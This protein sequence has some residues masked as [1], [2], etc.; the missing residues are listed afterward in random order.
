MHLIRKTAAI[1][2]LAAL[3]AA[4]GARLSEEEIAAT[5]GDGIAAGESGGDGLAAGDGTATDDGTGTGGGVL[6]AGDSTGIDT[7]TGSGDAGGGGGGDSGGA[8]GGGGGGGETAVTQPSGGNGGATDV[9]V[10]ENEILLGNVATLTGPVPGLFRGALVGAQAWAAYQNSIGGIHGRKV[11]I[12]PAD[13]R[14][15]SNANRTA[16]ADLAKKVYAFLGSFSVTEEAGAQVIKDTGVPDVGYAL[17]VARR[18]LPNNFSPQPA[19]EGWQ[20]GPLQWFK[21]KY[22]PEVITKVAGFYGDVAAAE[23]NYRNQQRASESIGYKYLFHQPLQ[24]TE[25]NY[26]PY[27]IRMRQQGAR[28]LVM[29]FDV[30]GFSR[31][32]KAMQQQGM[33]LDLPIYGGNAYDNK[34]LTLSGSAAEGA[35]FSIATAMYLG[36]DDSPEIRIFNQWVKKVAADFS[37]DI[38]S[39]FSW[40]AG[41]LFAQAALAGPPQ[42]TRK[43]LLEQL[44]KIDNFDANGLLPPGGPASKRPPTCWIVVTVKDGKFVRVTPDKGYQCQPGGYFGLT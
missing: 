19:R 17:S 44:G 39:L 8:G 7:G 5:A 40:T 6:S 4:C 3:S 15:D 42:M 14:L 31:M 21:D 34:F 37:P 36:Q 27:V 41:R 13:D 26:T 33:K 23:S 10:T 12:V 24:P 11:R 32:A 18:T 28:A 43:T 1:V 22:G 20:M 35:T 38:F 16:H 30:T 2:V 25:S 9:G 29:A